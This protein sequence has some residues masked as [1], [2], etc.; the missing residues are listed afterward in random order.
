VQNNPGTV[1]EK[2]IVRDCVEIWLDEGI[3]NVVYR[4]QAEIDAGIKHEMHLVFLEITGGKKHPFIF[5]SEG[6]LWY[7]RE[8]REY[9]RRIEP[10][11]PF[12]AVAVVAP[13][14]GYRLLADFYA[15]LYKPEVP[16]KVFKDGDEATTWLRTFSS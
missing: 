3:I 9:A 2:I 7:T 1:Q 12:L 8:G 6:A 10:K 16:Y 5:R 14:L 13:S 4:D 11:Q 15:R